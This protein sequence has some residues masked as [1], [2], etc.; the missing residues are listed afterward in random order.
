MMPLCYGKSGDFMYYFVNNI[1]I[2]LQNVFLKKNA[3]PK[4]SNK[5]REVNSFIYYIKGG[6]CFE[7]GK[8]KVYAREGDLLIMP[9]GF[10]YKNRL[11][12]KDTEYYQVDFLVFDGTKPFPVVDAPSVLSPPFSD[13][14]YGFFS[15]IYAKYH[16]AQIG[17]GIETV[18]SVLNLMSF[19]RRHEIYG[20][21]KAGKRN[22]L[23]LATEF[24]NNNYDKNFSFSEL[25]KTLFISVSSLEKNFKEVLGVS[26]TEY[27]NNVRIEKAKQFLVSG[28]TIE[29]V[30]AKTG[31]SDR[32]YFSKIFKRRTG[33]SPA[34][35]IKNNQM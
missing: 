23:A 34:T 1:H 31:F 30:A 26:P 22:P 28:H 21:D 4:F 9:Y 10:N 16:S 8:N 35:F 33:V 32:Y 12:S 20:T 29:E 25:A 5:F 11:L 18:A 24:I 27:R 13:N 17:S 19:V 6:Q 3:A 14:V 7:F 15:N 2:E